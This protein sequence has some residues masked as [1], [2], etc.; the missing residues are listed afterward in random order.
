MIKKLIISNALIALLSWQFFR[1]VDYVLNIITPESF[2]FDFEPAAVINFV[3]LTSIVSLAL[4]LFRKRRWALASSG[5]VG[6][7]FLS[8][9]G[10]TYINLVGVLIAV[11]LFEYARFVGV[12]E[13]DQRTKINS[14]MIVR[15]GATGVVLA[16][17]VLISFAAYQSPVAKGIAEAEQLPSATQQ[18]TRSIVDSVIGTTET[19]KKT[20]N[21]EKEKIVNEITGNV[22]QR[23]NSILKPYFQYAPPLL[24]FGLFLILWGLSWLFVWLSVL[25]GMGIFWLLKKTNMVRIEKRNVEA[26]ILEI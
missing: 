26:E 22:F 5:I 10:F 19:Q 23:L 14:R 1:Y 4:P 16:F 12:E 20:E 9:F 2:S 7:I 25:V 3:I 17:F 8:F 13:I 6:V 24:A 21:T 18:L 11:A 15:R